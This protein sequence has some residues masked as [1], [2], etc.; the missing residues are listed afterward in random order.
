MWAL[1]KRVSRCSAIRHSPASRHS[2]GNLLKDP[3]S[4]RSRSSRAPV[5]VRSYEPRPLKAR[6]ASISLGVHGC[7]TSTLWPRL[8]LI[9]LRLAIFPLRPHRRLGEGARMADE[10]RVASGAVSPSAS[11]IVPVAPTVAPIAPAPHPALAPP[12]P[13]LRM[14]EWT[15]GRHFFKPHQRAARGPPQTPERREYP[16]WLASVIAQDLF[17]R[18]QAGPRTS[19]K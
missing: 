19:Q 12:S 18:L 14:G 6:C 7:H 9:I 13:T 4:L 5:T 10:G 17:V 2:V 8:H 11:R 1:C 3:E 16:L 15:Y